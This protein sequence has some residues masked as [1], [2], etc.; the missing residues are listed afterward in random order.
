MTSSGPRRPYWLLASLF[1]LAILLTL[2]AQPPAL[3]Q[4]SHGS[5]SGT[6]Y[7][8][9]GA[10]VPNATIVLTNEASG[11]VRKTVSNNEGY[12]NFAAVDPASYTVTISAK[13][14][15]GWE[16]KGIVFNQAENHSL[17]N[18]AL[19]PGG[20]TEKVEV[21]AATE[22][23]P[24]DTGESR[25]TL[26]SSMVTELAI[27]GRDAAELIKI[28]PGMGMNT[29]LQQTQF[30]SL[31]TQTNTGPI[32]MYSANGG[33]PYGGLSMTT[34][35]AQIVDPGNQ[36]TQIANINQ[37]QT[38]EVTI[39]N[40]AF[41]ADSAKG[42]VTF[43]AIGKSGGNAFHGD[44]Y[45][46]TRNGALNA[47][48]A[49]FDAV[50]QPK[51]ADS[52][53]YPGFTLGG[54]VLIPGTSFNHNRDKLFFFTGYEYMKQQPAGTLHQLLVPTQQMLGGDFSPASLAA[55]GYSLNPSGGIN[56]VPCD[57]SQSTQWWYGNF[58]GDAGLGGPAIQNGV[59]PKSMLDP[60]AV[61]L[62][63]LF[64]APNET[65]TSNNPF[66]YRYLDNP[67]VN[68]WEYRAKIDYNLSQN[69]HISGS[70]TLQKETDTNNFGVWWEP[71]TTL[72]YPTPMP[73]KQ[74]SDTFAINVTHVF[75]PTLTNDTTFAYAY[76]LNPVKPANP[77]A[78]DPATIGYTAKGPFS[79]SIAPTIPNM[80]S[81][82]CNTGNTSGCFPGYYAPTFAGGFQGGAFG[83]DSKVP[84]I[85]DNISKVWR[86]HSFKFGFYWDGNGNHQTEGY[87]AWGQ[88]E[89]VFDNYANYTTGN[90]LADFLLGHADN[91]NQTSKIPVNDAKYH[92][93]SFYAMDQ[94]K[95]SRK[96]TLTY[97]LRFDHEGQWYASNG[98][99]IAVFDPS[100]Y[101][102]DITAPQFTGLT[103]NGIN[104]SIPL[105]G[106]SSP[107]FYYAPRVGVAYD[108]FGNGN[109]V[110]RGG[111]G[112]YRW[113]VAYNDASTGIDIPQGA[114]SVSTPSLLSLAS[115]STFSPGSFNG[116]EGASGATA[117]L[118]K[119]DSRTPY[120]ENWDLIVSQHIPG[121]STLE[122]EYA[123]N[124][125]RNALLA[126]NGTNLP[127]Y[128]NIDKIPL[129]GFFAPDPVNG[130]NYWTTSCA[131]SA[132]CSAPPSA[133][134]QDYRPYLNYSAL[135]VNTHGSY[136]NYNA[137]MAIWQKQRGRFTFMA[138][139][140]YSKL[141]GIRDGQTD[142]GNGDGTIVDPYNLSNNY[143]NLAYDHTHIFNLAY[144]VH[145]PSPVRNTF[146]GKQ[147][148]DGWELSGITQ[149]QSGAPLQPNTNGNLKMTIGGNN[150]VG[151]GNVEGTDSGVLLPVLICDPSKHLASGQYFNP[152]CFA[153]PL[154]R[155]DGALGSA[156][157]LNGQYIWPNIHGPA[158]IGNDLSLY[159]TFR[160][161]ESK[162]VQLRL[163]AFNF[164]NHPLSQ[165]GNGNDI[166]LTF[167]SLAT[168]GG[169]PYSAGGIPVLPSTCTL[170]ATGCNSNAT[171]NGKPQYEVGRRVVEVAIKFIF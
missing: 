76:F 60:N 18:I 105:S 123:G 158:Y 169:I 117:V 131:S 80:V 35:G 25:M 125:T 24:L 157:G 130:T 168:Q 114:L 73:A 164:L 113:Q 45:L 159:K 29:G 128:T 32:G 160:M 147:V 17:P 53:Y 137:F 27:Q 170:G 85:S 34:D 83:K 57:A 63:T 104:K 38:A 54:P 84:S 43:Q 40:S 39:L 28:M 150:P 161:T 98:P 144:V 91:Y 69:T 5:L 26:N 42:P 134:Y 152:N 149:M 12:F 14:F 138:N 148:L 81:W 90:P 13:G 50:N 46:Y 143:G 120:T 66:N 44:A 51:P 92:Q 41:G 108:L 8:A 37:D 64:P 36:G 151:I 65:P 111:Y 171:T 126:G 163:N 75:S 6:V 95:A 129:G 94:W 33:Q 110:I 141:L 11:T 106:W 115:A 23:V 49:Y 109:T 22:A 162:S 107:T 153:S 99:G 116:G 79:P 127:F 132:G 72:P 31:T 142:N 3:G 96:L 67:P 100:L 101:S 58:C 61:A 48:D 139:Y 20:E 154:P 112:V 155:Q 135:I 86:T 52:Y 156:A 1:V 16:Q 9:T 59:I 78:V 133:N 55:S 77:S 93:I 165:F 145:L 70:Y 2:A 167:N 21:Q 136:S 146:V 87:G 103:W 56:A 82:G 19:K 62:S 119:G 88:G 122:L 166:N 7:D 74:T 30:S 121:N 47:N 97:G 15:A 4:V 89:F 140:T 118:Q 71:G 10:V 68:R 102:N 124:A